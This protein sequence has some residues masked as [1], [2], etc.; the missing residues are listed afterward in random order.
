[1][2]LIRKTFVF[3][4]NRELNLY[5]STTSRSQLLAKPGKG[6]CHQDK[7]KEAEE[8]FNN[9]LK[10]NPDKEDAIAILK[11]INSIVCPYIIP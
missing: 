3:L 2:L 6:Y 9:I 10:L 4:D 5:F 1:M 11:Q 8:I 7:F